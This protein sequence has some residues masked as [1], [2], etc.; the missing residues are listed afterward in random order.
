MANFSIFNI[1]TLKDE[2]ERNN[3]VLGLVNST[4][5]NILALNM[6][7]YVINTLLAW[8]LALEKRNQDIIAYLNQIDGIEVKGFHLI[9][10]I[11]YCL[12]VL[13]TRHNA[14]INQAIINQ[15]IMLTRLTCIHVHC[16]FECN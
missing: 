14:I 6:D 8:K 7:G 2:L 16:I 3:L 12:G 5:Q 9:L 13:Y 11:I 10:V 1:S 15:A 4:M